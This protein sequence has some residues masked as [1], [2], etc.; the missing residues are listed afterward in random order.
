M[1]R[2]ESGVW[3][4]DDRLLFDSISRH[5]SITL[6][7]LRVFS[8]WQFPRTP[9]TSPNLLNILH[10]NPSQNIERLEV[11]DWLIHLFGR[12]RFLNFLI[13]IESLLPYVFPLTSF[14]GAYESSFV[15]FIVRSRLS[16]ANTRKCNTKETKYLKSSL[17]SKRVFLYF[18]AQL[19]LCLFNVSKLFDVCSSPSSC[20]FGTEKM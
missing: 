7:F 20:E 19:I 9:P 13:A 10:Q 15:A 3:L 18:L 5:A 4:G 6:N 16:H 11:I 17:W 1:G 14:Y 8:L 2:R 12:R